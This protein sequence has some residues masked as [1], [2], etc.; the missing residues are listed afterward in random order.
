MIRI[1]VY[2]QEMKYYPVD[3]VHPVL[4]I[5]QLIKR[6]NR[7][8]V[9]V[10]DLARSRSLRKHRCEQ[11]QLENNDMRTGDYIQSPHRRVKWSHVGM[12]KAS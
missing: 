5:R 8:F 9:V 7:F 11:C 2:L 4:V 3:R 1:R 10:I 12:S 6:G